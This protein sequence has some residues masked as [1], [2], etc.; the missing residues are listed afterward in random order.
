VRGEPDEW[1]GKD[2]K[3]ADFTARVVGQD[4]LNKHLEFK[5]V[6]RQETGNH[7]RAQQGTL[8]GQFDIVTATRKIENFRAYGQATVWGES[9]FTPGAPKGDF[10]LVTAMISA[11]DGTAN[12]IA[13]HAIW[14]DGQ[15]YRTPEFPLSE[16]QM[17]G[18]DLD[19][20]ETLKE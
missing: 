7:R 10:G 1:E 19:L 18:R 14:G 20:V 8:Y 4:T 9:R 13:P 6:Y 17:M 12:L 16:A 2:V 5:G 11:D 15:E 3:Q